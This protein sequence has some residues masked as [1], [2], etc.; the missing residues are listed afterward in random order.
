[1]QL[2]QNSGSFSLIVVTS[3]RDPGPAVAIVNAVS[4]SARLLAAWEQR[5]P[6]CSQIP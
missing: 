1:M 5:G 2:A 6:A 3:E 4:R